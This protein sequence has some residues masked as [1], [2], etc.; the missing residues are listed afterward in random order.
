MYSYEDRIRAVRL[1]IKLWKRIAAIIRQLGY[2]TKN[3]L[4][5]WCQEYGQGRD[6]RVGYVCA[7]SSMKY[8]ESEAKPR[9]LRLRTQ[10]GNPKMLRQ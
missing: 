5:G 7:C 6:L 2:P 10:K 3:S 8:P 4:K 9:F 1:Y